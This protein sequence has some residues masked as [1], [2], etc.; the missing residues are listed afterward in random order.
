MREVS[1]WGRPDPCPQDVQSKADETGAEIRAVSL[2]LMTAR[3][4]LS[5]ATPIY[6]SWPQRHREFWTALRHVRQFLSILFMNHRHQCV[7]SSYCSSHSPPWV[8]E[9]RSYS[10]ALQWRPLCMQEYA[11]TL[12]PLQTHHPFL[13]C[14]YQ[15]PFTQALHT[16]WTKK[17]S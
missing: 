8:L 14:F 15:L 3:A 10:L 12:H 2:S 5:L 17:G 7:C 16:L 13:L 4:L 1:R 6:W 11:G 9:P